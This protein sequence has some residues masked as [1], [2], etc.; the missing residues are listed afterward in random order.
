ML[1]LAQASARRP[2]QQLSLRQEYEEFILQRIE[3]FKDRLSRQE[4]LAIADDAVRELEVG[5]EG[6]LVLTEVLVLEHVDRLIIRRLK[7]PTYRRW[8]ERHL[9]L[10]RAQQ[11][12]THWGLD[13]ETPVKDLAL[14]LE[15]ADLA[16]VLGAGA[17]PAGLF[18]AAHGAM[19]LLIDQELAAVEAVETRA[20]AEGIGP[21]FQA[22]VVNL[23]TWF[24]EAN[25]SLVVV[26]LPTASNL[27]VGTRA[28]VLD[29]VKGRTARGGLHC[30]LSPEP[31]GEAGVLAPDALRGHYRDWKIERG[32]RRDRPGWLLAQKP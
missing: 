31:H 6:Q 11:S 24:P 17:G 7:L 19:V 27:D 12:P 22:L 14:C 3:E 25:P 9:K 26:D 8:R 2:R 21:K 23:G 16:L 1:T 32:Q 13:P 10:R 15:E 20:A 28:Q 5:P 30:V 29:T 18:L 4:L